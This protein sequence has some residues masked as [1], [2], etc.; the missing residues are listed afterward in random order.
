MKNLSFIG[1]NDYAVTTDGRVYSSKSNRFLTGWVSEAGYHT[2]G[3]Y[4]VDSDTMTNAPVHRLV[5]KAFI[6]NPENK[7]QVNHKDGN[8]LNNAVENLEWVSPRE[9]SIHAIESGLK[10][11]CFSTDTTK[12]PDD[13]E[14]VHDWRKTGI[15]CSLWTEDDARNVAQLLEDGYRVCDISAITGLDRRSIQHLRDG[16]RQWGFLA[17]E[18][19]FSEVRRK[20]KLSVEKIVDICKMLEQGFSINKTA[21]ANGVERK[22]VSTIYNRKTHKSVSAS[23]KW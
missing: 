2:V 6:P 7:P 9:N 13:F 19:D 11:P 14:V 22:V 20:Q 1:H 17:K 16:E 18:Y 4:A 10:S 5:A 8:K 21:E 12:F 3:L 15:A 23:F